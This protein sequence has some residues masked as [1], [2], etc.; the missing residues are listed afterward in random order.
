MKTLIHPVP[1]GPGEKFYG[2]LLQM[3]EMMHLKIVEG[4]HKV[5]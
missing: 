2:T 3:G 4:T 5:T 1:M